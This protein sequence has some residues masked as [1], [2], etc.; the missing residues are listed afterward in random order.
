MYFDFYS[1]TGK[2]FNED[3]AYI[4]NDI[5][6]VLDASTGLLDEKITSFDSD[7][8]WFVSRW[9]DYLKKELRNFDK[10]IKDIVYDG[11]IKI[12]DE[13]YDIAGKVINDKLERPSA[14]LA[15]IRILENDNIEYFMLGDC[16]LLYSKDNKDFIVKDRAVEKLD[17]VAIKEV[18][19]LREDLAYSFIEARK[20]VTKLLMSNRMLKNENDGY[21]VLE[22]EEEAVNHSIEGVLEKIENIAIMSDGYSAIFDTYTYCNEGELLDLLSENGAKYLY[23]IIRKIENEDFDMIQYPRLKKGD[24]STVAFYHFMK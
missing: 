22:F 2:T 12:R 6:F 19:R 24:D 1:E 5:A 15:I 11:I 7:G 13:F 3:I 10:S 16:T 8:Q 9:N 21:F 23:D 17:A 18:V 20:E 14:S 4:D